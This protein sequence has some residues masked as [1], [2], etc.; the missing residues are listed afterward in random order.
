MSVSASSYLVVALRSEEYGHPC[1]S[2]TLSY[3]HSCYQ[4]E[5]EMCNSDGFIFSLSFG[6]FPWKYKVCF[7]YGLGNL[8]A[9]EAHA[10]CGCWR[11]QDIE[12]SLRMWLTGLWIQFYVAK[13][14]Q[15]YMLTAL[16]SF[17]F[18]GVLF[19]KWFFA[20]SLFYLYVYATAGGN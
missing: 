5:S 18:V 6:L 8:V 15:V 17:A 11:V 7:H 19:L 9:S 12:Q 14:R 2:S 1:C 3:S 20:R 10:N 16:L 4:R 13:W